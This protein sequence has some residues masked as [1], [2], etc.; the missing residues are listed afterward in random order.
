MRWDRFVGARLVLILAIVSI[1]L[2]SACK[3][4]E[5]VPVVRAGWWDPSG[6]ELKELA[7]TIGAGERVVS[8]VIFYPGDDE[9]T[10][11]DIRL[12]GEQSSWISFAPPRLSSVQPAQPNEIQLTIAVPPGTQPGFY[13]VRLQ[14][15]TGEKRIQPQLPVRIRVP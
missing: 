13:E 10:G 9:S 8:T 6:G 14:L 12:S 2:L 15:L 7:L 5:G 4:L 11:L 3:V 1:C